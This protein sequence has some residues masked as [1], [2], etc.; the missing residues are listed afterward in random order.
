M[1]PLALQRR[2]ALA[3][4]IKRIEFDPAFIR[5]EPRILPPFDRRADQERLAALW[6]LS[7]SGVGLSELEMEPV[8]EIHERNE[9]NE[10]RA[11]SKWRRL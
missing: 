5:T 1:R 10:Q 11:A 6:A 7:R 4:S 9:R 3:A 8:G 2:S